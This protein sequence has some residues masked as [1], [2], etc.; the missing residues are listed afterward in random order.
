MGAQRRAFLEAL[1]NADVR[2]FKFVDETGTNLGATRRYGRALAGQRV[3]PGVALRRGG[4]VTVVGALTP[5][6]LE[7][8]MEL[9]GALN[10]AAFST[11]LDQVLGPTPHPGE[12][13]VL[14]NLGVHKMPGM[15]ERGAAY[16]APLR[17]LP[18]YSPDFNPIERAW[19]KLKTGLRTAQ[20][21]TR[22]ALSD[23]L[24]QACNWLTKTDAQNWFAHGGYH[25]H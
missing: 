19:S 21:R 15:A 20:A 1:A 18:P 10:E 5:N 4:N 7:V 9:D 14:D 8:V 3:G 16:G 12:V 23:A 24:T 11:W 25:V 17:F 22:Q 13:V 6:G 2:C